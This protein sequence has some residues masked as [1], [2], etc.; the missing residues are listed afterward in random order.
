MIRTARGWLVPLM[1]LLTGHP[2]LAQPSVNFRFTFDN[3]SRDTVIVEGAEVLL[4]DGTRKTV[5]GF[6]SFAPG[7]RGTISS[8]DVYVEGRTIFYS[9]RLEDGP[10]FKGWNTENASVK[11]SN[12][13]PHVLITIND[14]FVSKMKRWGQTKDSC[15]ILVRNKSNEKIKIQDVE[16][17][18]DDGTR[19][20]WGTGEW[21]FAPSESATLVKQDKEHVFGKKVFFS[22]RLDDGN[23]GKDFSCSNESNF[24]TRPDYDNS[25]I[26]VNISDETVKQVRLRNA[27]DFVKLATPV[28]NFAS[29]N[30]SV[31]IP[32]G[33]ALFVILCII[34]AVKSEANKPVR[35]GSC[36]YRDNPSA[37]VNKRCPKCNSLED[38]SGGKEA[39]SS[40]SSDG[41]GCGCFGT[42]ILIVLVIIVLKMFKFL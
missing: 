7:E 21:Q 10:T 30:S 8:K 28:V 3:E 1:V 26:G 11:Y 38:G 4:F 6:W 24:E 15:W 23:V 34:A 19:K 27:N 39:A 17:L 14:E 22:I 25:L 42:I 31:L 9:L 32:A 16:T 29:E 41:S 2:A 40:S 12:E 33:I 37:F 18:L 35:C 13:N 36:G 5:G 20:N